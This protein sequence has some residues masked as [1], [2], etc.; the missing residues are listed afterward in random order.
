MPLSEITHGYD[1]S[2]LFHSRRKASRRSLVPV[3]WSAIPEVAGVWGRNG[4]SRGRTSLQRGAAL[5]MV[6]SLLVV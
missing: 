3:P 2:R 6:L 1:A 5:G 4:G